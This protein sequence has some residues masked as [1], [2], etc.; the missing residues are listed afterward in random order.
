M[1][2]VFDSRWRLVGAALLAAV[3]GGC[4][5]KR[6]AAP[7]VATPAGL[8][9]LGLPP[10]HELYEERLGVL[11]VDV[12]GAE[13]EELWHQLYRRWEKSGYYP[14]IV[15]AVTGSPTWKWLEEDPTS[16][17]QRGTHTVDS[18]AAVLSQAEGVDVA[19]LLAPG[20]NPSYQGWTLEPGAWPAKVKHAHLER[21]LDPLEQRPY[22]EVRVALVPV[23]AAWKSLAYLT[24]FLEAGE[25]IPSLSQAT[26]VCRVWEERYAAKI[27]AVGPATIEWLVERPIATRD[28]ALAF[29]QE[30]FAF[31]P[32]GGS[33]VLEERAASLEGAQHW[34]SWWD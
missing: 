21:H 8:E 12:R 25:A 24:L 9:G 10:V 2:S 11:Y 7:A 1:N 15:G 23:D 16:T 27:M 29:A 32:E 20:G 31:T 6:N 13:V 3:L 5:T 33:R 18:P 34:S 30:H 4:G 14:V 17:L 19:A 22:P 26:A 28:E